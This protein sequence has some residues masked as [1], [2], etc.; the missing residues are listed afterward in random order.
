[1]F[2]SRQNHRRKGYFHMRK[3]LLA[4]AATLAIAT[5]A[6]ARDN[7]GYVGLEGGA[8]FPQKQ[9]I[10]ASIDFTDPLVPDIVRSR[11][12]SVKYKTGYDVDLIGG[13]DFGMFRLEGELGYKRAKTKSLSVDTAFVTAL[14]AGAGTTFTPVTD[15]GI[16]R[17]TSVY[18]AMLNGLL[19]FGGEGSFGGYVGGGAG[20]ASVHQLGSSKGKF[21]WQLL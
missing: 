19:D 18:S 20:Y 8:L 3:L 1:M 15:F 4:T 2:G 11:V 5:P 10:D 7:S 17:K 21:A 9:H 12:A 16:N 6:A 14:N 13:Y